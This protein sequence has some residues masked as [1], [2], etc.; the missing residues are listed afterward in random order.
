MRRPSRTGLPW[1]FVI[2]TSLPLAGQ[3]LESIGREKPFSVNGGIS[4]N[5]I[6]YGARG[7]NAR[8]DAYSYL[9]AG[10]FNFLV[11][12]WSVPLS[13]SFSNHDATFTQ[14]FN[15]YSLH[16]TWKSI[17]VHAGY[18]SM[19]FSPYTVNGHI[20]SGGGIEFTPEGK[21]KFCAL[22]GRFLK[23]VE[24]DT[25]VRSLPAYQRTGYAFKSSYGTDGNSIDLILFHAEDDKNSIH[26]PADS[27]RVTPHENL[28]ISI[29]G[30]AT[31]FKKVIV[32]GELAGSALTR[33][34]RTEKTE[35][36]SLLARSGILFQP[37]RTSSYY[38]A[39][40]T[41]LDYQHNGWVI[42]AGYER[43]DPEYRTL[44]A[45]YF[46]NDLE[47]ITLNTSTSL[48]EGRL[49]IAISAG[50]Q[51]DNLDRIKISTMRRIVSALNTSFAPSHRL[52]FSGS[53][54]SFQ[55]YTNIRSQFTSINELTP[56]DNLDTLNFTQISRNASL[57][58]MYFLPGPENNKQHVN[59]SFT[60]QKAAEDQGGM[61]HHEGTTFYNINVAY[62]IT[63]PQKKAGAS[64]TFN[65]TI[66]EGPHINTRMMGPTASITRS[67]L[68]RKLRSTLSSSWNKTYTNGTNTSSV[69]NGRLN[70][71]LS[72]KNKHNI[73]MSAV[74]VERTLSE[75]RSA[76][77]FT[78]TIAYN[79]TFASTR[80]KP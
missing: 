41:S 47:N 8:R 71:L 30:T 70:T 66:N 13:F 20:F 69:I 21:W 9:A 26:A 31:L 79:Y 53:W 62:S 32:R 46:N 61:T 80:G 15:Q 72:I 23:A 51:H 28:V 55:T 39:V 49:N 58:G 76:T 54:S 36:Q 59:L 68:N 6:F 37:R 50:V 67:F 4:F 74:F 16:P 38:Q 24:A 65:T 27:L 45:Y 48:Q 19:S 77:E 56:Y 12:G 43:I 44:G 11:Y 57:S 5:Q 52:N 25:S 3:D 78:A 64:L 40:K 33:D 29:G 42:G 73:N 17:T 14:P 63:L 1:L 75:N 60:W 34:V 10:N 18:T 35:S 7:V 2:C 22:Y